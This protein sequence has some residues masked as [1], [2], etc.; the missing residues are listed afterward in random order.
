MNRPSDITIGDFWGWE[1]VCPT[2]NVDD[3]GCSVVLIN[4]PKGRGWFEDVKNELRYIPVSIE[5]CMQPNLVH[6]TPEN[7]LRTQFEID[8]KARG[9]TYVMNKYSDV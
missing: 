5:N 3:M 9:F 6:P 4:T 2:F 8:Y 7:I 1:K